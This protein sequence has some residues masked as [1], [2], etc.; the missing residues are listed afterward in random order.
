MGP[1]AQ[2]LFAN[3]DKWQAFPLCGCSSGSDRLLTTFAIYGA[4]S[5]RGQA[6]STSRNVIDLL[7]HLPQ[8][9]RKNRWPRVGC[10]GPPSSGAER[11][12]L[13]KGAAQV[14][15]TFDAASRKSS[16]P[17]EGYRCVHRLDGEH[18]RLTR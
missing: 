6:G 2:G 1:Y 10:P 16:A 7:L 14:A 11:A 18:Y 17:A 8:L 15:R 3:P 13:G 9:A 5:C 12:D 4:D